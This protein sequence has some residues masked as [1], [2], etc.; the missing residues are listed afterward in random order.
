MPLCAVAACSRPIRVPVAPTGFSVI[1]S[2]AT[3]TGAFPD[4]LREI[5]DKMGCK[6]V[7]PIM[8]RAR[9]T[10]QFMESGESDLF[11]PASR[12]AE[13][14]RQALF[15][16]MM[17]LKMA[18]I[19]MTQR[20]IRV[21]SVEELIASRKLQGVS[22]RS[23]VFGDEYNA[24][25]QRLDLDKRVSYGNDPLMVARMLKAGRGDFTI[26]APSIFLSSLSEDP[27]LSDL[28][29][30]VQYS[31]L[32]GLPMTDSGAYISKRSLSPQD[33]EEL[34]LLL[35]AARKNGTLWKMFQKYYPAEMMKFFVVS[36]N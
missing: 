25:M 11:I 32:A 19:T 12:S 31:A 10:F 28:P 15:I 9:L 6:F 33:Q 4:M 14:D 1:I 30:K 18:L 29:L 22:V 20:D 7:F 35:E 21:G 26:V 17:K 16:P 27:D 8:P 2:G 3:V 34:R 36:P 23:Y 24:L 5:G 13:R